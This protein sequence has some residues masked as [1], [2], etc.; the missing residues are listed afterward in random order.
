IA[1]AQK[2]TATKRALTHGDY[3]SWKSIQSPKLSRDGKF[4]AYALTPQDG[5]GELVVRN[6]ASGMEWRHAIGTRPAQTNTDDETGAAIPQTAEVQVP[7][8]FF[9]A[10]AKFVVFQIRPAKVDVDRA[11][12]EKK[13]PEDQPKNALGIMDLESGNVNTVDRV[14][15]FQ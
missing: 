4:L 1:S 6:L 15:S 14:K 10:D 11:R 9:T 12:K 5:D 3:D 7:L 2:E 8:M 13:K